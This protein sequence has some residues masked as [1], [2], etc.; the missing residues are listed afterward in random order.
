[1]SERVKSTNIPTGNE[2]IAAVEMSITGV[3]MDDTGIYR[4]MAS[5]VLKSET[6]TDTR[7]V[8]VVV[9]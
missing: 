2:H 4:C 1:M 7:D 5:N 3:Q 6:K 9:K 8:V